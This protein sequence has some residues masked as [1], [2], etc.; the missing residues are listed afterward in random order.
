MLHELTPKSRADR[1]ITQS[2]AG[3]LSTVMKVEGAEEA[4][5]GRGEVCDN[6]HHELE[7]A[8]RVY[9]G[10]VQGDERERRQREREAEHDEALDLVSHRVRSPAN[11][12]REPSIRG[13][14]ADR[15]HEQRNRVRR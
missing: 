6:E 1:S 14:V 5:H 12:E 4:E 11:G 13:G 15:G 3:G 8:R 10:G 7:R 2:E 9:R